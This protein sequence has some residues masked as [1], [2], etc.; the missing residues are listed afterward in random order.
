VR[1]VLADIEISSAKTE[2][3][4]CKKSVIIKTVR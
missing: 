2:V 4:D 1:N 3:C